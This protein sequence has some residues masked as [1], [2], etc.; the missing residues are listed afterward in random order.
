MNACL[1]THLLQP[2]QM[3]QASAML[4]PPQHQAAA[5]AAD[6]EIGGEAHASSQQPQQGIPQE[7]LLRKEGNPEEGGQ[8]WLLRKEGKG[9][10]PSGQDAST[11]TPLQVGGARVFFGAFLCCLQSFC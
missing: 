1:L 11:A 8:G 7:Q 10:S 4:Q 9:A 6:Q 2:L 3:A 5:A